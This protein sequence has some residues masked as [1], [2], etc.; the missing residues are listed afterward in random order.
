MEFQ[1]YWNKSFETYNV[2]KNEDSQW[3]DRY[4]DIINNCKTDI[5]DLGCG[6]GRDSK[7]FIT[8]NHKIIAIDGC[9]KLCNIASNYIGQSV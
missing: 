2:D 9:K 1:K 3:L 6:A 7:F 5:L 8:N 4:I